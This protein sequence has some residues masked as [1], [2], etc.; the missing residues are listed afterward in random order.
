MQ[1]TTDSHKVLTELLAQWPEAGSEYY[2]VQTAEAVRDALVA[3]GIDAARLTAIGVGEDR[4]IAPNDT[5]EGRAK[6]RRVDIILE[7]KQ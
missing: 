5:E 2:E 1:P 6:N 4:P 7:E 3:A